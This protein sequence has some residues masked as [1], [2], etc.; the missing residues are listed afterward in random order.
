MDVQRGDRAALVLEA[1]GV[2]VV[3]HQRE[4]RELRQPAHPRGDGRRAGRL[5]SHQT[6]VYGLDPAARSRVNA[7]LVSSMFLG[8]SAGAA[9]ASQ[10]LVRYG[11]SG[12]MTLGAAAATLAL[13]V[14]SLPERVA[15]STVTET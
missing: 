8:M 1:H 15:A 11:W 2:A 6:I 7:L 5:I 10:V 3:R 13:V 4:P 12:V 14:R 9:L